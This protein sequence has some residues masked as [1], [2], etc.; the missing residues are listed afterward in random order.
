MSNEYACPEEGCNKTFNT[1]QGMLLHLKVFHSGEKPKPVKRRAETPKKTKVKKQIQAKPKAVSTDAIDL[2]ALAKKAA[3]ELKATNKKKRKIPASVKVGQKLS[4]KKFMEI[5]K[6]NPKVKIAIGSDKFRAKP[7]T[8]KPL[9]EWV[10]KDSFKVTIVK[11]MHHDWMA[12]QVVSKRL[13]ISW[14]EGPIKGKHAIGYPLL[15]PN[16]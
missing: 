15:I 7:W 14:K 8:T 4:A 1:E 16:E 9:K 10:G 5:M 11:E 2:D 6:H 12:Y 13:K 3:E